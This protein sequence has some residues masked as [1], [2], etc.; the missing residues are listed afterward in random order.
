VGVVLAVA[1]GLGGAT[2]LGFAA[3]TGLGWALLCF[4]AGL[5]ARESLGTWAR[6]VPDAARLGAVA[7]IASWPL[8]ASA[9][10][11]GAPA[12]LAAG[13]GAVALAGVSGGLR[14]VARAFVHRLSPLRQRTVVVGSGQVAGQVARAIAAHGEA[15]LD[16]IGLVDDDPHA[17]G[18][19]DLPWLGAMSDLPRVLSEQAVDRVIVAF[20][21]AGHDELLGCLRACRDTGV[22][23]DVVPRLFELLDGVDGLDHVGT[24]PL[25]PIRVPRLGWGSRAAKRALDVTIAGIALVALSPVLVAVAL[26]IKLTSRGPLLFRQPR[27][28]VGG[29]PFH[30]WKFRSMHA[31]AEER[32]AELAEANEHGDGL[33]FKLRRD[34]RITRVGGFLRRSTSCRSWSTSCA[35]R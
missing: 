11:A 28:G 35:A 25:L 7:L 32:K 13:G 3:G 1:L 6:G 26:A 33:M 27:A 16:A 23:V 14:A 8:V 31:D 4:S 30:V 34:P 15:G 9:A 10:L 5:S 29:R 20:S 17:V 18:E 24:V 22:A 21:R 2:L 19:A 12:W